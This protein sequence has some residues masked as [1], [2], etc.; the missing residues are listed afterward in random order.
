MRENDGVWQMSSSD[1]GLF[2]RHKHALTDLSSLAEWE[3][4]QDGVG[5]RL[6]MCSLMWK[7]LLIDVF[8]LFCLICF[9]LYSDRIYLYK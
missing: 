4:S 1:K 8:F 6:Y 9:V 7:H 3:M 5:E 2:D